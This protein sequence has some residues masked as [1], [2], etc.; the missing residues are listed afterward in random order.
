MIETSTPRA[1]AGDL[2][3]DGPCPMTERAPANFGGQKY[4]VIGLRVDGT[5]V[6]VGR[7]LALHEARRIR[8]AL[9]SAGIF[10]AVKIKADEG[11]DPARAS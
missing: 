7:G 8:E 9:G 6:I 5:Q 2:H 3:N 10:T 4:H 11:S 1:T